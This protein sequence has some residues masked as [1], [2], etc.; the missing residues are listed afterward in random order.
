MVDQIIKDTERKMTHTIEKAREN[1]STIRTGRANPQMLDQIMVDYYGTPTPLA[2]VATVAAPE[3][4]LLTITPWEKST[5]G[6]IEKAITKSEINLNPTN[7]GVMIRLKVPEMTEERRKE[8]VKLL[9]KK[10]EEERVAIR[11][12]RREANDHV[13]ALE[14]KKEI[15]EDDVK[16]AEQQLQKITDKFIQ[17]LDKLEKTKETE[18]MAI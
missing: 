3:P 9:K 17:E 8:M 4:R 5:L 7:D 14:K 2:H 12:V 15:S 1:F 13:K 18:V 6:P 10:A 11:N 16:R